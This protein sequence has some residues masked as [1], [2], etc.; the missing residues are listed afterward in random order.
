MI[1]RIAISTIDLSLSSIPLLDGR[2]SFQIGI[3]MTRSSLLQIYDDYLYIKIILIFFYI[4]CS[5]LIYT[6]LYIINSLPIKTIMGK[7]EK[8]ATKCGDL[9]FFTFGVNKTLF[10]H[11]QLFRSTL[12]FCIQLVENDVP[13]L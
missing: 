13:Y 5:T 6:E 7:T 1:D 3:E 2:Q 4:I 12:V 10:H 8:A 9:S 11:D